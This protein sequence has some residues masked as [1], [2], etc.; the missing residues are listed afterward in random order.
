MDVPHVLFNVGER[1]ICN[2]TTATQVDCLCNL[3]SLFNELIVEDINLVAVP[4]LQSPL[5]ILL[6]NL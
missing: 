5:S 2:S 3:P 6:R 1:P 4:E